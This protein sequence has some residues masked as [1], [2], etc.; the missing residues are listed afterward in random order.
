M[1]SLTLCFAML[2][3]TT[4]AW[5]TDTATTGVN[6]IQAGKL[7]IQ[8]L[9]EDGITSL[10]GEPLEFQKA[11]GAAEG[12]KIFWEPGATYYT[13]GFKI[14]NGGDL[15]LKFNLI[16][17][18]ISGGSA[19]LLEAIDFYITAAKPAS[20]EMPADAI[21]LGDFSGTAYTLAPGNFFDGSETGSTTAT[22]LYLVGHMHE[23]AGNEYQGLS[24][25]GVGITVNATQKDAESDSFNN[26]YDVT[27]TIPI[28]SSVEGNLERH[29][30]HG[31]WP[32]QGESGADDCRRFHERDLSPGCYSC[33]GYGC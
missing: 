15:Y 11:E 19:E 10:E 20:A 8:L 1:I 32:H 30:G 18:G 25:G 3:G 16:V 21:K 27:A 31:V 12:E 6:K 5:F 14:K 26:K 28:N 24:I 4:F 22:T 9:K 13:Q 2:Q 29:A 7:D 23:D 33:G 17:N